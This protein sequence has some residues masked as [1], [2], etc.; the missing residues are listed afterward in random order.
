MESW[1]FAYGSNLFREQVIERIG[2]IGLKEPRIARLENYRLA[3]QHLSEGDPAY[4][5][6]L[7]PGDG[8]LGVIYRFHAADLKK[9]DHYETGYD[10]HWVAVIDQ[11]GEVLDAIA[12]V[13]TPTETRNF[14]NP[15]DAYLE[16]IVTGARQYGIPEDYISKI[17][18][19][20]KSNTLSA[21]DETRIEHG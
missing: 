15:S 10:R 3:F 1:Y 8:V 5:N 20:A 2:T 7:S 9:M 11:Y 19:M 13:M 21:T 4:A 16:R 12:Y 18:T 17:V 14:G 6:I